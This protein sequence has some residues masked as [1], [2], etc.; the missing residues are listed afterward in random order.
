ML[1]P[2]L[3]NIY[4]GT[5]VNPLNGCEQEEYDVLFCVKFLNEYRFIR[6]EIDDLF[7]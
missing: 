3:S 2:F 5:F 6:H 4:I 1:N 7:D